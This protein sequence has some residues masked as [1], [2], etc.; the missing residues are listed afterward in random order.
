[1]TRLIASFIVLIYTVFGV[2]FWSV[3]NLRA[4]RVEENTNNVG[5][6][7]TS[8]AG[9][10]VEYGQVNFESNGNNEFMTIDLPDTWE[11]QE[12][13]EIP[14]TATYIK[15]DMV[16][17][18]SGYFIPQAESKA[19]KLLDEMMAASVKATR[20]DEQSNGWYIYNKEDDVD[21][22]VGEERFYANI[23]SDGLTS[24]ITMISMYYPHKASITEDDVTEF[25]EGC[26]ICIS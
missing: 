25:F 21:L 8:D 4:D 14:N 9:R 16:V 7:I 22:K 5:F 13:T 18:I 3:Y 26:K 24:K 12:D 10:D 19:V 20:Q 6:A 2:G 1:M 23:N 17:V 11:Y 15:E